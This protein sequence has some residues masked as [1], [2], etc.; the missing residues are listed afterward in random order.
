MPS[1]WVER[2]KNAETK[3]VIGFRVKYRVG[4][5][6]SAPRYAGAFR[7][8]REARIRRDWIAG[9][10]AAMRV[11]NLALL[12][13]RQAPLTVRALA[14]SWQAAR[15]D[16][17]EGTAQTYRVAL[18]RLLPRLGD[19]PAAELEPSHV[20][21]LVADLTAAGLRKQTTRKTV[22]VLAMILDHHGVQPNPARDKRVKLPREERREL[23]PPTADHVLAVHRLLPSV[24]RLPLLVLDATGMRVGELEA[25][26]WGDVDEQRGRW[27]VTANVAK[28]GAARWV[29][30]PE[31]VFA[32]VSALV[33]RDDR[34]PER[35]VFQ[36]FG[37][38]RFRT[39][40]TRA[41]TASGVPTFSP[42]DLRHRRVSLLHAQG[43]SWAR[44]GERVGHS[45]LVTT[46]RTYTHVLG[47]ENE[48][49][50]VRL[51]GAIA[52]A[53]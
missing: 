32:A 1:S 5:R 4:G 41:C 28:T 29:E 3:A 18:G 39:A 6:E 49:D 43:L 33:P 48:L 26:T 19:V 2:R 25:L 21:G 13:E 24:Y 36:G 31:I 9:E 35:P 46:A 34:V 40:I 44:I 22:S 42:H 15:V 37:A 50:Y 45:D 53:D 23:I 10:L 51:L 17:S 12:A 47:D 16:V 20:A 8:M 14:E 27:R 30:P 52:L 11:P 7:T 38:D